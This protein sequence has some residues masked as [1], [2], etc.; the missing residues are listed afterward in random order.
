LA[1]RFGMER[2]PRRR[3]RQGRQWDGRIAIHQP[4]S[5]LG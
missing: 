1:A 2:D 3:W 4:D 5:N